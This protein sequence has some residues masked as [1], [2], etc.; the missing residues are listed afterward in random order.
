MRMLPNCI[1][2]LGALLVNVHIVAGHMRSAEGAHFR[3]VTFFE[4][5]ATQITQD[6]PNLGW[7]KESNT[8]TKDSMSYPFSS[9][10]T[11]NGSYVD[12]PGTM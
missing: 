9:P 5:L 8:M 11:G 1:L 2:L 4:A 3:R 6:S 10:R 7:A 12:K